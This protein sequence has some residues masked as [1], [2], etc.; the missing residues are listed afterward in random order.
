MNISKLKEKLKKR[1]KHFICVSALALLLI[2]LALA[3][4]FKG[5]GNITVSVETSLK[6]VLETSQL[7]TVEYTYNSIAEKIEDDVVKY[8]VKYKGVVKAGFDFDKLDVSK[9]TQDENKMIITIPEIIITSV[10]VDEELK[11]IFKKE[12][13]DTEVIYPEAYNLCHEDLTSKIKSNETFNKMAKESAEELVKG[14][15]A[16]FEKEGYTFE[17]VHVSDNQEV[18]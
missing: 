13:Y 10:D 8:Y 14:L 6:E 12:R 2:I 18:Q 9:D 5:S 4:M 17:I 16:P 7:S 15:T 11:Y 1:P 3:I